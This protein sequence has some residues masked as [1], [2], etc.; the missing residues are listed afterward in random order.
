M[1]GTRRTHIKE[2]TVLAFN[3][4][5]S[6]GADFVEFDVQLTKDK[7]PI[8]YHDFLFPIGP[9]KIPINKITLDEIQ[10]YNKSVSKRKV[11]ADTNHPNFTE[12]P[13]APKGNPKVHRTM[14]SPVSLSSLKNIKRIKNMKQFSSFLEDDYRSLEDIFKL[15]PKG[16][17]FN[18]EIKYPVRKELEDDGIENTVNINDYVDCILEVVFDNVSDSDDRAIIFSSFHPDICMNLALKQPQFPVLFLTEAGKKH[19]FDI[20]CKSL[21]SAIAFAKSAQLFGVV[22]NV[23][24]ILEAPQLID[25]VHKHGLILLTYGDANNDTEVIDLQMEYGID[26]LISDH[27]Q[28]VRAHLDSKKEVF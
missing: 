8:I 1:P 24:A 10:S 16:I 23:R 21:K 3:A 6:F 12:D 15:A 9:F 11:S 20:R 4:A 14:S 2:N 13:S 27:V 5:K 17:G 7:V 28:Y 22:S 26:G 18:I 25:I 19:K